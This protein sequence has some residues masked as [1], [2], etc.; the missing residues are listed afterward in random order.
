[1]NL[2][3]FATQPLASC[4]RTSLMP[5]NGRKWMPRLYSN[6]LLSQKCT[7]VG[8]DFASAPLGFWG[9]VYFLSLGQMLLERLAGRIRILR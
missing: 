4:Q 2:A 9:E 8:A 5:R 3:I 6:R 7:G 1:M